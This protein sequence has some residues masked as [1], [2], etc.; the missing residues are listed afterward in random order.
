MGLHVAGSYQ[1]ILPIPDP[2]LNVVSRIS[3]FKNSREFLKLPK[4]CNLEQITE[5]K[6]F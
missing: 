4:T 1:E 6:I 3:H 2:S 5:N